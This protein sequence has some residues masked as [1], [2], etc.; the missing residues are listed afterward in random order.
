MKK[1]SV[2][3]LIAV[4]LTISV[5]KAQNV[6]QL[7]LDLSTLQQVNFTNSKAGPTDYMVY[8]YLDT[9][10]SKT[11]PQPAQNFIIGSYSY[12]GDINGDNIDDM[13]YYAGLCGDER[14]DDVFDEVK[15]TIIVYEGSNLTNLETALYYLE[16]VPVGD[17]NGDGYSDAIG[18]NVDGSIQYFWGSDIGL[19]ED[20]TSYSVASFNARIDA[21][22][23]ID[24]DGYEDYLTESTTGDFEIV[25]GGS[26]PAAFDTIVYDPVFY[27]RNRNED[28]TKVEDIDGTGEKII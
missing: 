7:S 25:Y 6:K 18:E 28:Y 22:F 12:A 21:F 10:H 9:Y 14:T 13:Y 15:K 26:T 17:L 16:L 19:T 20:P 3:L 23:D 27:T 24:N 1:F 5:L 8:D 4:L 2:G 11:W